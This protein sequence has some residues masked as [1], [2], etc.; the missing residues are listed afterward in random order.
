MVSIQTFKYHTVPGI[1]L[2]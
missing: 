1:Y 2:N